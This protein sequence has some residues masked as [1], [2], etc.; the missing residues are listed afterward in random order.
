MVTKYLVFRFENVPPWFSNNGWFPWCVWSLEFHCESQTM[1]TRS[2][3]CGE[4]WFW[5]LSPRRWLRRTKLFYFHCAHIL[6]YTVLLSEGPVGIWSG[7]IPSGPVPLVKRHT[8]RDTCGSSCRFLLLEGCT[9]LI[10]EIWK[11]LFP[12]ICMRELGKGPTRIRRAL[13]PFIWSHTAVT[14]LHVDSTITTT[15]NME[16]TL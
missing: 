14:E 13:V 5:Q 6:I 8:L 3:S 1:T 4:D 16:I 10:N 11:P 15:F 7:G 12:L 9:S 2:A